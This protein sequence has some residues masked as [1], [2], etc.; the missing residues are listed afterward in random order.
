M[1]S[2]IRKHVAIWALALSGL[3]VQACV[4]ATMGGSLNTSVP[5][6]SAAPESD[7]TVVSVEEQF[8]GKWRGTAYTYS[9][10]KREFEG[11][12]VSQFFPGDLYL[13]FDNSIDF[14]RSLSFSAPGV[15]SGFD[16]TFSAEISV[17]DGRFVYVAANGYDVNGF[18]VNIDEADG[19]RYTALR[20]IYTL[21]IRVQGRTYTM[22][23][24]NA[25]KAFGWMDD[26]YSTWT[27]R[28]NPDSERTASTTKN[29][30]AAPS[31]G[32]GSS[33][34]AN[35]FVGGAAKRNGSG[36]EDP[37]SYARRRTVDLVERLLDL[38]AFKDFRYET[39]EKLPHLKGQYFFVKWQGLGI[40]GEVGFVYDATPAATLNT[41]SG[42]LAE[43]CKGK[44][45]SATDSE[46]LPDG[47][48]VDRLMSACMEADTDSYVVLSAFPVTQVE[49]YF[50]FAT[51]S[52]DRRRGL[53]VDRM[54]FD[55]VADS[56]KE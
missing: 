23:M 5:D 15:Q 39:L 8:I 34:R 55:A 21:R 45:M 14:G 49:G 11:C 20:D 47:R 26:C 18:Y 7:Y 33:A 43:P 29:P 13:N 52:D 22:P 35:P 50:I 51:Y 37:D 17:N 44:Y 19:I 38:R 42:F 53:A 31:S 25:P 12:N 46:A 27:A 6:G 16:R 10:S 3:A 2:F 32:A 41:I 1:K 30:F 4:P 54:V 36:S 28:T 9:N 24:H 48:N 56:M 40:D